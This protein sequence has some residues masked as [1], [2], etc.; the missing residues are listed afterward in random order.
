M[1]M[2]KMAI[3][4][5]TLLLLSQLSLNA[6]ISEGNDSG[7]S[8]SPTEIQT[9][10][11][12]VPCSSIGVVETPV[13]TSREWKYSTTSGS[14]YQSFS[15]VLTSKYAYPIFYESGV[16]YVVCESIIDGET[17][18]SNEIT[19]VVRQFKEKQPFEYIVDE[20]PQ[21]IDY[22]NDGDLDLVLGFDIWRNDGNGNFTYN[23]ISNSVNYSSSPSFYWNDFNND[24][25]IDFVVYGNY[26]QYDYYGYY[27]T[28]ILP[29]KNLG[30][31]QFQVQDELVVYSNGDRII[32]ADYNNDG[33][34]DI[35][36]PHLISE[37]EMAPIFLND[38]NGNFIL[39]ED[40]TFDVYIS[41]SCWD[42]ADY[43]NDGN[44][45]LLIDGVG[46]SE[47][48][49]G[50]H[51]YKNMGNDNFEKII[52][53]VDENILNV[54]HLQ[55]I[56]YDSD[57]DSDIFLVVRSYQFMNKYY[58]IIL[59]NAGDEEFIIVGNTDFIAASIAQ[60]SWADFD[61]DGDLDLLLTGNG[62][63][64]FK[65]QNIYKNLGN[66]EFIQDPLVNFTLFDNNK[67]CVADY[68]NDGDLDI[69]ICGNLNG[70]TDLN[71]CENLL[72]TSNQIPSIPINLQSV[73]NVNKESFLNWDPSTDF[74]TP[75]SGITYNLYIKS[76]TD[77]K[78]Y[79]PITSDLSTG[80]RK[81]V[82]KAPIKTN[83]HK[84]NLPLGDYIWKVQSVDNCFEGS[85][86]SSENNFSVFG[87]DILGEN[88]KNE[89]V[90]LPI[91]TLQIYEYG[92]VT[93]REWKFS[94]ESGG[95]YISFDPP[96]TETSISPIFHN[97]IRYYVV[98]ESLMDDVVYT[99]NE[100]EVIVTQYKELSNLMYS[101]ANVENIYWGDYDNDGILE[102]FLVGETYSNDEFKKL[103]KYKNNEFQEQTNSNLLDF[104]NTTD[105][106][107]CWIDYNNDGYLD[108][109]VK[110]TRV[111]FGNIIDNYSK[112]L[113]NNGDNSFYEV[114]LLGFNESEYYEIFEWG[115]IDNDGK[116]DLVFI[117]DDSFK[118][119]KNL[120]N[121]TFSFV[122]INRPSGVPIKIE[123]AD[124]DNSGYLDLIF[125]MET[126][127]LT[128][129]YTTKVYKNLGNFLFA[130]QTFLSSIIGNSS[131]F[132]IG[133]YNKD[134]LL[135]I[136]TYE[137][138][139]MKIFKNIGD[140]EFQEVVSMLINIQSEPLFEWIDYDNDGDLDLILSGYYV[141][142]IPNTMWYKTYYK[143][144]MIKNL[145]ND[146]F[147]DHKTMFFD[148]DFRYPQFSFVDYDNDK[149]LDL[150]ITKKQLSSE[151]ETVVY[152]NLSTISNTK[153]TSPS[154]LSVQVTTN[155]VTLA[156]DPA[157]DYETPS[158]GLTYNLYIENVN[159]NEKY[160]S[161]MASYPDG[162][163]LIA[164]NGTIQTTFHSLNLPD[165]IY[166]W[167]VQSIDGVYEG[168]EF[169]KP[170]MFSK[171][172]VQK[173]TITFNVT[174]YDEGNVIENAKITFNGQTD[175]TNEGGSVIFADVF[176]LNGLEYIIEKPGFERYEGNVNVS[177]DEIINIVLIPEDTNTYSITFKISDDS[178]FLEDVEVNFNNTTLFTDPEGAAVFNNVPEGPDK[179]Y[180]ISKPGYVEI[181]GVTDVTED[182]IINIIMTPEDVDTY[183]VTFNV[184]DGRNYIEGALVVFNGTEKITGNNG[185]V[186]FEDITPGKNLT[187][188]VSKENYESDNGKL[189]VID[190]NIGKDIILNSVLSSEKE[191]L[192]FRINDAE[193]DII[194]AENK[195]IINVPLETDISKLIAAFILSDGAK[196]EVNGLVQYSGITENDFSNDVIYKVIA[197]DGSSKEWTV[198]VALNTGIEDPEIQSILVYPNPASDN[199]FVL[200]AVNK[201]IEIYSNEG[202]L[203]ISLTISSDNEI[204]DLS[205]LSEGI[206]HI[207]IE[208]FV[209]RIVIIR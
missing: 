152:E 122:D 77:G 97:D 11:I 149:D 94:T 84:M 17:Y 76:N 127:I 167:S 53:P 57:G 37:S 2:L 126:Y 55:W 187:Y 178:D 14:G 173:Y 24:G 151:R 21:W 60:S 40:V 88:T 165:G 41:T 52:V 62:P 38:R 20:Q 50:L 35:L 13:A 101:N 193:G 174:G 26:Y 45:D 195:I 12:G 197:E 48:Q 96:L 58:G 198:S 132:D 188:S 29:Y 200:N 208:N 105:Q 185:I 9:T 113:L 147:E 177:G 7:N 82:G 153:P 114:D 72:N 191:I 123:L 16:F 4:I 71:I 92:N 87:C 102:S 5:C 51:L 148:Y 83:S 209:E 59:K 30:N 90:G 31:G 69:F 93:S 68:D 64:S 161:T 182:K 162:K 154:N 207:Q 138:D 144:N 206:Y 145:G 15:P 184:S 164:A 130:E 136:V 158:E 89:F 176:A 18:V 33:Y 205:K 25:N 204:V 81:I 137:N 32:F 106:G 163:R 183:S 118:I 91:E 146:N 10:F 73:V 3:K 117:S 63:N 190:T 168:S 170:M 111:L 140:G 133:D 27:K 175:F 159:T 67:H 98:C 155:S 109:F 194:P 199:I 171:P 56:D 1:K 66:D 110:G 34:V 107:F 8:I 78:T 86:F 22:D 186:I 112:V 125:T 28:H 134:G 180:R 196:A 121:N 156:W 49:F 95:N 201:N 103:Y 23:W 181:T 54:S 172:A 47:D 142:G 169:S 116:I 189:D 150:I 131:I 99:S 143:T 100:I 80:Y 61:N 179:A 135:D 36:Y 141:D 108:L 6:Q 75:T 115:D 74:E 70:F 46:F 104:I 202:K 129:R 42:W 128:T 124:L 44:I 192:V 157:T 19:V 120:G 160:Y 65:I 39:K 85:P 203:L 79:F 139:V 119:Y 166:L 43:D